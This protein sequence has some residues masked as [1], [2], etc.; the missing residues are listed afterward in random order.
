M[1]IEELF[2]GTMRASLS[3]RD[4]DTIGAILTVEM[5]FSISDQMVLSPFSVEMHGISGSH[6]NP[7][8]V[9]Q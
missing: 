9:R 4:V 3:L 1:N 5:Q 6:L 8:L 7:L 2:D